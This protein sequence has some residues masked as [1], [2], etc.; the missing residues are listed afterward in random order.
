MGH[1]A[2]GEETD[3]EIV[4]RVQRGDAGAFAA[5][6]QRHQRRLAVFLRSCGLPGADGQDLLGETFCRALNRIEQ[7]DLAR[8]KRY[9]AYLYAIARNLAADHARGR[10]PVTSLAELGE[11]REPSD[12][13]GEETIVD[14]IC[15]MEQ[16]RLIGRAMERL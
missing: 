15:W 9:L 1:A 5:I 8:G 2:H 13:L 10:A 7:F 14:Q 11:D 12:S 6:F 4:A 16:V 3:E